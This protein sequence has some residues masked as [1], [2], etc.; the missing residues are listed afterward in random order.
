M[1]TTLEL[2]LE[3]ANLLFYCGREEESAA[4][5]RSLMELTRNP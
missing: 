4:V 1:K 3:T 2:L 5:M